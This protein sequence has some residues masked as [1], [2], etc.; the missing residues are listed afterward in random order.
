M[1]DDEAPEWT[2]E[3]NLESV[4]DGADVE[5]YHLGT[6]KNGGTYGIDDE[7]VHLFRLNHAKYENGQLIKGQPDP[8][9]LL[10]PQEG[11]LIYPTAGGKPPPKQEEANEGRVGSESEGGA[12]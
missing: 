3:V 7:L 9:R 11:V 6:F 10:N 1:S 12:A 4:P 5:L 2:I 8:M